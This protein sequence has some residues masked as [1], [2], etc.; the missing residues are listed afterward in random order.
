MRGRANQLEQAPGDEKCEKGEIGEKGEKC[1]KG[2]I[3]GAEVLGAILASLSIC[4]R[5]ARTG[6]GSKVAADILGH[7]CLGRTLGFA[8][9]FK[10]VKYRT[11]KTLDI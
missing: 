11:T 4:R 9:N 7:I 8:S 6:G 10:Q 5:R 2:E 3:G 1:E